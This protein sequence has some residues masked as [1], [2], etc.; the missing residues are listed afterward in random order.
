[1]RSPGS[2]GDPL[3]CGDQGGKL[4]ERQSRDRYWRVGQRG[5]VPYVALLRDSPYDLI[6]VG[7]LAS[8]IG[9]ECTIWV[10]VM[11]TAEKIREKCSPLYPIDS[12]RTLLFSTEHNQIK[13]VHSRNWSL[14]NLMT[15][16]A[17]EQWVDFSRDL[18]DPQERV[19]MTDH[20][21]SGCQECHRISSM[22][23][24]LVV[25]CSNLNDIEVPVYAL[26]I[27]RAI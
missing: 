1:M 4:G 7:Q 18:G 24:R 8:N 5:S 21:A 3:E 17:M 16:Y 19:R 23:A 26:R 22:T 6:A 25:T 2:A 9:S 13:Y 15:H 27:A 14:G 10:L 11:L 12:I 20:L